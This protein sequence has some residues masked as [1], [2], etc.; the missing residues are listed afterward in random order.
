MQ[1]DALPWPTFRGIE[2][3]LKKIRLW[4]REEDES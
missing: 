1:G 3:I 2:D 4:K